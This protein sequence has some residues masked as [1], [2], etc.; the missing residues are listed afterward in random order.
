MTLILYQNKSEYNKIDK[1][2]VTVTTLTGTLKNSCSILAP[3]ILIEN[4]TLINANY[5]YIP[6]YN[7]YYF[8]TDITVV[9]NKLF[10]INCSVDVLMSFKDKIKEQTAIIARQEKLYNLYL[11]DDK[12]LSYNKITEQIK[13]F[14]L[15]INDWTI[16]L[17]A[18]TYSPIAEAQIAADELNSELVETTEVSE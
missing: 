18:S 8:I 7:R 11:N 9:R 13:E 5:C 1:D 10:Q 6:E 15:P 17:I 12:L 3:V 16:Y 2:I 14:N 4:E